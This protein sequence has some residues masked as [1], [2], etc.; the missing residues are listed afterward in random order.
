MRLSLLCFSVSLFLL[1]Y[2]TSC[3]VLLCTAY[4]VLLLCFLCFA[5]FRCAWLSC[6]LSVTTGRVM[7]DYRLPGEFLAVLRFCSRSRQQLVASWV[8]G[9]SRF[10]CYRR[11]EDAATLFDASATAM[12][13]GAKSEGSDG[14]AEQDILESPLCHFTRWGRGLYSL[15]RLSPP[16]PLYLMLFPCS[17]IPHPLLV[18][19][20]LYLCTF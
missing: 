16:R 6:T 4:Q 14:S 19:R 9:V 13:E 10:I 12:L 18:S 7:P 15:I 2:Y 20:P 1:L 17:S 8:S 5:Y 3:F 11:T